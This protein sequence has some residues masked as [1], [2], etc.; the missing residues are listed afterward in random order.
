M[1]NQKR[2]SGCLTKKKIPIVA[3]TTKLRCIHYIKMNCFDPV[4]VHIYIYLCFNKN[5]TKMKKT[6]KYNKQNRYYKLWLT[7]IC[8]FN[9]AYEL[10][11]GIYNN[12][13]DVFI[14]NHVSYMPWSDRDNGFDIPYILQSDVFIVR[15]NRY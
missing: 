10:Y 4:Y 3:N 14:W 7:Y 12:S 9:Y 11:T 13:Y 5:N 1:N 6:R 8:L 15:E 2:N